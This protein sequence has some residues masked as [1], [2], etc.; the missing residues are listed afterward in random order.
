LVVVFDE[1]LCD[2]VL[3]LVI[4]ARQS[5]EFFSHLGQSLE[6]YNSKNVFLLLDLGVL[7]VA[8]R[9]FSYNLAYLLPCVQSTTVVLKG[10]REVSFFD[11]VRPRDDSLSLTMKADAEVNDLVFKQIYC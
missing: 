2:F 6:V 4:K 7:R 1:T 5:S 10:D 11:L 8:F 3:Y 9:V